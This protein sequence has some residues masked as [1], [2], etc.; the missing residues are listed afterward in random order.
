MTD[1]HQRI[2]RGQ[3]P[4]GRPVPSEAASAH[5]EQ[6]TKTF[7]RLVRQHGLPEVRLHDLR[8]YRAS[9][10]HAAGADMAAVS[11]ELGHADLGTTV[12]LY[13]HMFEEDSRL[14][15]EKAAALVPRSNREALA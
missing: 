2:E 3:L 7:H 8:H 1:Q 15:S 5:P 6:V 9:A 4:P 14:L 13:T 12:N 10:L 11:K